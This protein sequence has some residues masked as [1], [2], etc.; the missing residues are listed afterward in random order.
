MLFVGNKGYF[1]LPT[2]WT[3]ICTLAHVLP[4]F[5]YLEESLLILIPITTGLRHTKQAVTLIPNL[6][7]ILS[8]TSIAG[9]TTGSYSTHASHQ[10]YYDLSKFLSKIN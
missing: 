7:G 5:I 10:I 4:Q 3:G 6:I 2:N 8:L 9:V 1:I